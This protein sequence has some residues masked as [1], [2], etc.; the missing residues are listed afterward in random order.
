M[1]LG[2]YPKSPAEII[3]PLVLLGIWNCFSM[4]TTAVVI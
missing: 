2:M 4:D 1:T 3:V